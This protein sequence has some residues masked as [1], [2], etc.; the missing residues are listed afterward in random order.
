MRMR[1]VGF[2]VLLALALIGVGSVAPTATALE[3]ADS[4]ASAAGGCTI[5]LSDPLSSFVGCR[6]ASTSVA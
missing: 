5:D 6:S 2:T 4:S 3:V 1:T